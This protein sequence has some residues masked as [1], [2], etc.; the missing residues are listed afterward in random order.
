MTVVTAAH[1]AANEVCQVV[2]KRAMARTIPKTITSAATA[3]ALAG[4]DVA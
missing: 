4:R 1:T 3:I 2:G